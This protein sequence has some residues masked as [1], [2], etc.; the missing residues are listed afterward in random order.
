MFKNAVKLFKI[1]GIQIDIDFSWVIIFL[2]VVWILA[3]QFFPRF[4]P[5]STTTN[6]IL[7]FITSIVFFASV[8]FHELAHSLVAKRQ[9]INV[10]KITLFIFGGV[11][12]ITEEPGTAKAEFKM[13]IAGPLSSIFLGMVFLG[14]YVIGRNFLPL[15][16]KAP[17]GFLADINLTLAIFN[18]IPGFPLDGGRVFRSILWYFNKDILKSTKIAVWTGRIFAFF[19]IGFGVFRIVFA[20]LSGLWFI[21]IGFFLDQAAISSLFQMEANI[22]LNKI[23]VEKV[24]DTNPKLISENI[25][26][27]ELAREYFKDTKAHSFLVK[28]NENIGYVRVDN[29][30]KL[31]KNLWEE[32]RISDIVDRYEGEDLL[33]KSDTALKALEHMRGQDI[34][35]LPV[36]ENQNLVGAVSIEKVIE[37][38]NEEMKAGKSK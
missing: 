20:D 36:L 35:Q 3:F 24:M 15:T 17:I 2:L 7:G 27:S 8:I 14:I 16:L 26:V 4:Y 28:D 37:Y 13:A 30:N 25:T 11:S 21:L 29:V 1:F 12:Q 9:G 5:F 22:I 32:K 23:S 6:I 33:K 38:L 31:P 19:L 34:D 10:K 18:L